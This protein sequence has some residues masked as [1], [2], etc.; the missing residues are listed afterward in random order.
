MSRALTASEIPTTVAYCQRSDSTRRAIVDHA[1]A[2]QAH[3]NTVSAIEYLKAHDLDP[4]VIERVLL[5]PACR[6]PLTD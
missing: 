5:E 3:S 1:I 2:V 4:R 6:R